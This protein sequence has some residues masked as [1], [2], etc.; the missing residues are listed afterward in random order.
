MVQL[1]PI[2]LHPHHQFGFVETQDEYQ[3]RR[4]NHK[5]PTEGF[6]FDADQPDNTQNGQRKAKQQV[7]SGPGFPKN[8]G[9]QF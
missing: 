1:K 9:N 3:N 4:Q 6:L 2:L 8:H 7:G 5:P